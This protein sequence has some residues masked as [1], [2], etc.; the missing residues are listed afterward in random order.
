[1]SIFSQRGL[2][3]VRTA[4]ALLF[5]SSLVF[6]VPARTSSPPCDYE[7]DIEYMSWEEFR[8]PVQATEAKP[9]NFI[10][11][12]LVND[13]LVVLTEPSK[14]IHLINNVDRNSPEKTAFIPVHG[15]DQAA[16]RGDMLFTRSHVDLIVI[17]LS[18]PAQAVEAGRL[19]NLFYY[20]SSP[21]LEDP[22]K[23]IP[24]DTDPELGVVKNY[25]IRYSNCYRER[26]YGSGGGCMGAGADGGS[27]ATNNPA[28]QHR[29]QQGSLASMIIVD[30]YLYV[31]S[32]SQIKTVSLSEPTA[33]T[34]INST[35]VNWN[36]ETLY[37]HQGAIYVGTR[38]GVYIL[39]LSTPEDPQLA[40]SFEH[41]WRCD[42]VVV[43][44][45]VAYSTLRGGESCGGFNSQLDI[46]DVTDISN[47]Q[48][49]TSVEM[50]EPYGLAID[51]DTL[52][53]ADGYRGLKRLNVEDPANPVLLSGLSDHNVRDVI[54]LD[55]QQ[56]ILQG[57]SSIIQVDFGQTDVIE[58]LSVLEN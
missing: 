31:I 57:I 33:P 55:N 6:F 50:S 40:G 44:G 10:G 48:L 26:N 3:T 34:L 56:A 13:D 43:D 47:P 2:S 45:N 39:D 52:L 12:M 7:Y 38:L 54:I 11:N 14:G 32:N 41:P 28:P 53:V 19:E 22:D 1:M 49:I 20:N 58:V 4:S 21:T 15:V 5:I 51:D 29:I 23:S 36:M 24:I 27:A 25:T 42:P 8:A 18:E 46:L 16:M 30:D 17:D 35:T 37:H 9:F